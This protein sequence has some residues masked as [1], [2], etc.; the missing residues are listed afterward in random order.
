MAKEEF[1]HSMW[2]SG[3]LRQ[4]LTLDLTDPIAERSRNSTDAKRTYRH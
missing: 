4:A 2:S 1:V 3:S